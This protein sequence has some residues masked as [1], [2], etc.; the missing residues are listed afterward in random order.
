MVVIVRVTVAI[1]EVE[2]E[3]EEVE[4][5]VEEV[6]VVVEEVPVG[7]PPGISLAGMSA[8]HVHRQSKL[9]IVLP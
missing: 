6:E 2:E 4:E 5:V 3:V 7:T 8:L 9:D 1:K